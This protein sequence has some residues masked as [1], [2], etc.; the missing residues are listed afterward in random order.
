MTTSKVAVSGINY[1]TDD[2]NLS[3][4]GKNDLSRT[5]NNQLRNNNGNTMNG[6]TIYTDAANEG[7]LYNSP[8]MDS[9]F[10]SN[11]KGNS[12]IDNISMLR[13][14]VPG[15]DS[16]GLDYPILSTVPLTEFACNG[17]SGYFADTDSQAR[18]Q[19]I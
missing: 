3:P 6:G 2:I 19:V 12:D 13:M 8:N 9:V 1:G 15:G 16:P 17:R 7:L 11:G 10:T 14:A 4:N 5:Y 18:C